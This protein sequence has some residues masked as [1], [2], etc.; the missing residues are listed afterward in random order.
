M[1]KIRKINKIVKIIK[2]KLMQTNIKIHNNKI[3][4]NVK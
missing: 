4:N 1:E 3:T 2:D